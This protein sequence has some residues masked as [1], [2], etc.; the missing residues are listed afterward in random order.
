MRSNA[1]RECARLLGS[2]NYLACWIEATVFG[3]RSSF[4][5]GRIGGFPS[6]CSFAFTFGSSVA[7]HALVR[8]E[9]SLEDR[10]ELAEHADLLIR[11]PSLVAETCAESA[12]MRS[13]TAAG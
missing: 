7:E 10:R 1:P 3:G 6:C 2:R 12:L 9:I 5:C 11:R 4:A 8:E 13:T